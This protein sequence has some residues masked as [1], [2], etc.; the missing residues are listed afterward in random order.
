M[1]LHDSRR[2]QDTPT[3]RNCHIER[4]QAVYRD[5]R[6]HWLAAGG[7]LEAHE[8]LSVVTVAAGAR[9]FA[10]LAHIEASVGPEVTR[11]LEAAG[12]TTCQ[13]VSGFDIAVELDDVS[14]AT[15]A[16]YRKIMRERDSFRG[17][18]IWLNTASASCATMSVLGTALGYPSCCE[19]MDVRT[20]ERDHALFLEAVV[21]E[22][23][24]IPRRVEEALR[25]RREY[26]KRTEDHCRQ[27][28]RRFAR[29]RHLFP[30]VLH[31]A[32]EECLET[33]HSPSAVLNGKYEE[34]A[35]AVSSELH[36]M[37]RWGARAMSEQAEDI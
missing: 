13:C 7:V 30:F 21:D 32:C 29:T 4:A 28:G 20:K 27:W 9:D 12:L 2:R 36:L 3:V 24:D 16:S 18:G 35:M 26:A 22:E 15:I 14:S 23:G 1:P 11:L 33:G 17:L 37:V 31:T 34:V 5:I 6:S 8:R 10:F 25:A 19:Q